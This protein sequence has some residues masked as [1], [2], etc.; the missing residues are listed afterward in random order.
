MSKCAQ[1]LFLK[2][3]TRYLVIK[4]SGQTLQLENSNR[5]HIWCLDKILIY[6]N[7]LYTKTVDLSSSWL[8][9]LVFFLIFCND[10]N[11]YS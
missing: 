7:V 8:F 2:N 3:G 6:Q 4:I 10:E 1:T 9:A 11:L 5:Y